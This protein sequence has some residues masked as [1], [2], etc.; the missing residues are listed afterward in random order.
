[1]VHLF[2]GLRVR[3]NWVQEN[4]DSSETEMVLVSTERFN[5]CDEECTSWVLF[6]ERRQTSG[7]KNS[8]SVY[9][10]YIWFVLQCEFIVVLMSFGLKDRPDTAWEL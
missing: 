6:L 1:M 4:S 2:L 8:E 10:N 3:E 7:L 5:I 9:L